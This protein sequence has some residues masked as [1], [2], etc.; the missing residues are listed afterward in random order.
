MKIAKSKKMISGSITLILSLVFCIILSCMPVTAQ[1]NTYYVASNGNDSNSGTLDRP[2]KTIQKACNTAAAGDTVY[3]R[4]GT[5]SEQVKVNVSG[6]SSGYITI[7]SYPE[8]TAV[9]DGTGLSLSGDTPAA[10]YVN[11]KS[12]LK[13]VGF[14]IRNYKVK[15]NS[16]VPA[17]IYVTGSSNHIEIRNNRIHAIENNASSDGNAHGIAV[18][19]TNGTS[20]INNIILDANEIS[21]CKLGWSES[22]VLNG[23]VENFQVTNNYVHN[24]DNIGIDFI[25]WEGTASA[26]DQ[27]RNGVCSGNTVAYIDSSENPA[28]DGERSA[29]GIYCDGSTNILIEKN[30]VYNCNLGIEIASEHAN[31]TVSYITVRN[32]LIYNNDIAGI[33]F[34]G[35]DNKRGSTENCKFLNNT[36]YNNDTSQDGNGEI[37]IQYDTKN[38]TVK[39]NLIYANSQNLFISNDYTQ[40][41]G[42]LIDYNLYY[43]AAGSSKASW[44][45]KKTSYSGF[46]KY[47][48]SSGNDANSVFADPLFVNASIGNLNIG[49]SSPAIGAGDPS[50]TADSG[51]TDFDGNARISGGRVDCGAYEK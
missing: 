26:N 3:V 2:W 32:N 25:G 49:S 7:S 45:W 17:G 31:K 44:T 20:S 39:N 33:A 48:T 13:I 11:N 46:A 47:K 30:R 14:E 43:C 24:N 41:T 10:F 50:F 8:E 21:E 5:Y 34:G 29:D 16:S 40:N 36:L 19:G 15:S 38:N 27:V 4:G 18:Y 12:Y 6:S 9:L 28:Y 23:N 35:Y 1:S 51:E 42:N 37:Y 22:M